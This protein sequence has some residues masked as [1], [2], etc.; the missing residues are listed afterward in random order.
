[1]D[2]TPSKLEIATE[3][4]RLRSLEKPFWYVARALAITMSVWQLIVLT[5]FPTDPLALRALHLAFVMAIGFLLMG[6]NKKSPRSRFTALD[7][8]LALLSFS[9]VAYIFS[10]FEDL[11]NRTGVV[12]TTMDVVIASL[13]ILLVLELTRRATGIVL[14][15]IALAFL[16]YGLWGNNLPG[17]VQHS[18]YSYQRIVS[19]LFGTEGIYTI[20]VGV[21]ATYVFLFIAFGC[22]LQI[23]GTGEVFTDLAKAIAGGYRGG[24]AKVSIISSSL[25]GTISGS[26]VANVMVDGW[27]TI[28]L[29][30]R[31]GYPAHVAGAIEAVASTGGQIMPPVMGAGAFIMAE[32][33][34]KPYS[35]IIIA[36]AIPAVLYYV[37]LYWMVDFEA[38]KLKLHGLPKDQLPHFGAV[39]RTNGYLL[40]PLVVL[41]Y[42]LI[43]A[44]VS[45]IRAGLISIVAV[46]IVSSFKKQ[47][48][49]G[50]NKLMDALNNSATSMI[51][52]A[53][54]CA[55]AG[56]VIGIMSLTGLGTKMVNAI[57]AFSMGQLWLALFLT[58]IVSLILGM[59]VPTTPAYI[60]VATTAAPALAKLGVPLLAAHLFCFYF[61]CISA[62][63]PPVAL[64]AFAGAAIAKA[65]MWKVGWSAVKIG[66]TGFIVPYM[67]VYGPALLMMDTP[68]KVLQ[69][70]VTGTIGTICLAGG[71]QGWLWKSL[72]WPQRVLLVAAALALIDPGLTTDIFGAIAIIVVLA[73]AKMGYYVKDT[74][75][76][77]NV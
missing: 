20:P 52:V 76:T 54:T 60:I 57:M 4:A 17:L 48:R 24:P 37:A 49:L 75:I 61:A 21:S 32:I 39:M 58:M 46:L 65:N 35:D 72:H 77:Q 66:I 9:I 55:C 5:A 33:V 47:S 8:I 53:A 51:E 2:N 67:F 12:P 38:V 15:I 1:M 69:A 28:P 34:G 18:G 16:A 63:T 41:L 64:A 62:I 36:A 22:F 45:P 70:V 59:G 13:A 6:F 56:I 43:V 23:S 30:K 11:I 14:P 10:N 42:A 7:M 71:F 19:F 73:S 29:M 74:A 68:E 40:I 26:A 31:T 27:L 3:T 44:D 25:F 50:P